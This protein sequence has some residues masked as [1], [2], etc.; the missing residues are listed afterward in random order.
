LSL[1]ISVRSE[2]VNAKKYDFQLSHDRRERK[3]PAHWI[4]PNLSHS[5][6]R[7]FD[8]NFTGRELLEAA[9]NLREKGYENGTIKRKQAIKDDAA[10]AYRGV[11]TF[12]K[13]A[14]E[15]IN[16]LSAEKQN[17]LYYEI[18]KR[19]SKA[20]GAP[21]LSVYAHRD[22]QAPH[23]HYT[24]LMFDENGRKIRLHRQDLKKFQ[25]IASKVCQDFGLPISRGIPKE[26]RIAAGAPTYEYL[27]KTVAEL[28]YS[29][30]AA[31]ELK[32]KELRSI[33]ADLERRRQELDDIK[34]AIEEMEKAREERLKDIED[35][36]RLLS[37]AKKELEEL[38]LSGQAES[39]KAK[40]LEKRIATY[41]KRL[42]N[43]EKEI[44]E[45]EKVIN[46]RQE[47]IGN[48]LKALEV[49]NKMLI[50]RQNKVDETEKLK[51]ENEKLRN[52]VKDLKSDIVKFGT[53]LN[54]VLDKAS[55]KTKE[56]VEKA[57]EKAAFD[58]PTID[59]LLSAFYGEY[60]A[61]YM[62]E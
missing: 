12:G 29:L 25:D 23:A 5:N 53:R 37:K 17:K 32:E 4:N 31:I 44:A 57:I 26:Q 15:I 54:K 55:D 18:A 49:Y 30:P 10:I 36:Q 38:A 59:L 50:E 27:H 2:Y 41:E 45:K 21:L 42:S 35:K 20:V 13:E 48:A 43:Y 56:V 40:K 22:E 60:E 28:H 58:S 34:R 33:E 51:R 7:I 19:I 6:S 11:I 9:R 14:Q 8:K 62:R 24:M 52:I 39:E 47:E 46:E 16:Q 61:Q 3:K 1:T